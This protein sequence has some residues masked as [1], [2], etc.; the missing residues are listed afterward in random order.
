M[1]S[2][3]W[4]RGTIKIPTSLRYATKTYIA[5]ETGEFRRLFR[6]FGFSRVAIETSLK[7]A[8]VFSFERQAQ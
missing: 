5:D 6:H 4:W 7:L 8:R 2:A 1:T 3:T